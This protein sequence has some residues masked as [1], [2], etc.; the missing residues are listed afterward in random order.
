MAYL[1]DKQ[2]QDWLIKHS[3]YGASWDERIRRMPSAQLHAVYMR[4]LN[5][6]ERLKKQQ[7]NVK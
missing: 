6:Y 4:E 3:T 2:K 5:K 7:N 1:T